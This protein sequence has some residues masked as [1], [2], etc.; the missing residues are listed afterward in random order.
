[1]VLSDT[2]IKR[3]VFASVVSLILII[4]GLFAFDRLAVREYPD[5]DPPTVS[6]V[7]LYKGASAQIMETQVTQIIEE[8]IAGIEGIK[9]ITSKSREERSQVD[10]EFVL[11]RNVDTAANDVRD[12][13]ARSIG[14][15]PLDVEAPIV[16]KVE[17]DARPMLWIALTSD[18]WDAIQLSDYADRHLVD[19]LSVVPGV[20]K[21]MIGGERKPAIRIWLDRRAMAAR[22]LTVQDVEAALLAQNVELPSGRIESNLREFTVR[23]ESALVTPDEFRDLVLL[24]KDGYLVRLHEIAEV[25]LGT[26]E[27]RYEVRANGEAAIGLGVVKQSKANELAIAEGILEE[28][29]KIRPSLARQVKMKVAYD[30]SRFVD[31]S[32]DGVFHALFVALA[33]VVGVIFVFLRSLRATIIPAVAIPVSLTASFMVLA[34]LGYS[35]NVLTL[36][37]YVLAVGLVVDDA[38]VVLENIHR[39]IERGEPVLLASY[40]GARQISFAVI[41]TTLALVAV[42]IPISLMTGN[43]G[44]LFSEFGVTVAA[45]VLFSGLVALTLTPMMCSKLLVS[46]EHESFLYKATEFLFHLLNKSYELLLRGTLALPVVMIFIGLV[47][48]LVAKGFYDHINQEFAPTEDRGVFLVVLNAPEGATINYTRAYLEEAEQ[49]LESLFENGEADTI[50][51]VVA[52]GLSRPSPV[53]FAIA[54]VVLEPWAKRERKQ[55]EIVA[56]MFP[57]LLGI[58]GAM[59]FAINPPSLNQPG[60]K[61]PVQFVIGGPSYDMLREWSS[62]ILEGAAEN[63][64][65]LSIQSDF[66]ETKPELRVDIHRDRAAD[67]GVSIQ[68]IGRT[69]ETML[70]S[71]FVSTF[72]DRGVQYNV[73][74]QAHDDD[75][76]TPSDLTNINVRSSTTGKLISLSSLV[77]VSEAA[78]PKELNRVDRMRAVTI[79]TSL[80]PGYT[81]GEALSYLDALARDRLPGEAR[82]TYGGQSREFRDSSSSLLLTFILAIIIIYLVLGAQFESF[83]H[84][85]IILLSVPLAVTGALGTLLLTGITLNVYSQIG[86]VMLIGLVA[87]NAI[88]IVEFAN[89]LREQGAEVREAIIRSSLARFRPILMTTIATVCGAMPL[90]FADGAGAESRSSIGW[91]IIGGVSFSTIL[92]LFIVPVLYSILARFTRPSSHIA[93][94]L[95][96]LESEYVDREARGEEGP[97]AVSPA[98]VK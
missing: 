28:I 86:M 38:I 7:T 69:L 34:A 37:A 91:V 79:S 5:I 1:M 92:S 32:I 74:M 97:I 33:L 24:A 43:T 49:K 60:R 87:K 96:N 42:F 54:F 3:P 21:V 95:R 9:L 65:L 17:A 67:L 90:A 75:R 50:F 27:L 94:R 4:F 45:T 72:N 10:I 88:L 35:I 64:N 48:S 55:Q 93:D 16:S 15:L 2:S 36:L 77:T 47:I 20:A 57:K 41:A 76:V 71:R 39:R 29:E 40:R 70:G 61:T 73:V 82:I 53:N 46:K 83:I 62:V 80:A 22:G 68:A 13:V 89:Q 56:E 78:G 26:E 18:E 8:A 30:K 25:E 51:G 14:N 23:T 81:L 63:P 59:V 44:R 11:G 31:A 66:K 84:P 98:P 85:F 19:R 12:K 58:P 6:I 52:P